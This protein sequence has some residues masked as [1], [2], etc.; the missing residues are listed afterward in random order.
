MRTDGRTDR[1]DEANSSFMAILRSRL[2]TGCWNSARNVLLGC[3]RL[4]GFIRTSEMQ[5]KQS[6]SRQSVT[7]TNK[8]V[9]ISTNDYL[10][11]C[12]HPFLVS[13]RKKFLIFYLVRNVQVAM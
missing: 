11:C 3:G 1:H 10:N 5:V 7:I 4:E 13:L 2:K 8:Q 6:A 12:T 9:P